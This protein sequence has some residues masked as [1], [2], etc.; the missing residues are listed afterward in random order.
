MINGKV[1]VNHQP[2]SKIPK[3]SFMGG[4]SIFKDALI[5]LSRKPLDK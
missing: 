4:E 5:V 3:R 2:S 1:M